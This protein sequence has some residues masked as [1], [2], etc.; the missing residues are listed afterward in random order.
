MTAPSEEVIDESSPVRVDRGDEPDEGDG[1]GRDE[2]EVDDDEQADEEPCAAGHSVH[3]PVAH[4]VTVDHLHRR[5]P[6]GQVPVQC[7]VAVGE[8]HQQPAAVDEVPQVGA[9]RVEGGEAEQGQEKRGE[10]QAAGADSGVLT[11]GGAGVGVVCRGLVGCGPAA[12][13]GG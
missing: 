3:G 13:V 4:R 8:L 11:G 10:G 12:D 5:V 9:E 6:E 7:G 1:A 2:E